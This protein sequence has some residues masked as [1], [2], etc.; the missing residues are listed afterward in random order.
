MLYIRALIRNYF[1]EKKNL[2]VCRGVCR[3]KKTH[4]IAFLKKRMN[5]IEYRIYFIGQIYI[6]YSEISSLHVTHP[7]LSS[8]VQGPGPDLHQCIWS[9]ELT[10]Y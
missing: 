7:F 8:S 10:G 3:M 5:G 4:Q 1:I 2:F 9:R 6:M